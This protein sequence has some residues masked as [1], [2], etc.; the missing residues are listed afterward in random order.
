MSEESTT[1]DLEKQ[2]RRTIEALNRRD[3]DQA[4]VAYA[5]DAALEAVA[6]MG[7][8]EGRDAIRGFL[9]DWIGA[10]QDYEVRLEEFHDLGNGVTCSVVL[11]RGRLKGSSVFV[12]RP[13]A[14]LAT[15]AGGLVVRLT[16]YT[17]IDEAR[18]AAERLAQERG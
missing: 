18:A 6:G 10:Y 4:V 5:V 2:T 15:R 11:Q 12:E 3:F 13:T 9:E 8:F 7:T 17:D 1:P 16:L 14:L